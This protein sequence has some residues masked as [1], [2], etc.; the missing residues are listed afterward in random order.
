MD[1][2][3]TVRGFYEDGEITFAEPVDLDGCWQVQIVFL[4]REDTENV[5]FEANP[6]RPETHAGQIGIEISKPPVS[7]Y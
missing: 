2:N 4:E 1:N 3:M 5:P 6:H 7:P